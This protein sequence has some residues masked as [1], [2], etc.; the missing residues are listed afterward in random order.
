MFLLYT[1][2]RFLSIGFMKIFLFFLFFRYC[3]ISCE[4][5]AAA[6]YG[7]LKATFVTRRPRW[8]GASTPCH[9]V[10]QRRRMHPPSANEPFLCLFAIY[11]RF[12]QNSGQYLFMQ[13]LPFHRRKTYKKKSGRCTLSKRHLPAFASGNERLSS[14]TRRTS[15]SALIS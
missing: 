8:D 3:P 7:W 10:V 9:G 14:A 2:K 4:K 6:H 1:E 12:S 13:F 15:G 11:E 5:P